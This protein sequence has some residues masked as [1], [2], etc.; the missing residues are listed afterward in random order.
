MLLEQAARV[1]GHEY[2]A[3]H[4]LAKVCVS[5]RRYTKAIDHLDKALKIRPSDELVTYREAIQNLAIA[6]E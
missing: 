1:Q 4:E 5:T 3:H 6:S 2:S